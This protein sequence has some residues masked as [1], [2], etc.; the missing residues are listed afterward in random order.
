[1][2]KTCT[3]IILIEGRFDSGK[4][5][6]SSTEVSL[7]RRDTGKKEIKKQERGARWEREEARHA[8]Y[9]SI[10]N[11]VSSSLGCPVGAFAEERDKKGRSSSKTI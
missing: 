2:K 4:K 8:F 9:F 7:C 11:I 5:Y 6:L 10:Y 1:M 3:V